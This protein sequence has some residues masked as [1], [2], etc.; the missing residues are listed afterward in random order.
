MGGLSRGCQPFV[1]RS[2]WIAPRV[3]RH[4]PKRYS[5]RSHQDRDVRSMNRRSSTCVLSGPIRLALSEVLSDLFWSVEITR[6]DLRLCLGDLLQLLGR[7]DEGASSRMRRGRHGRGSPNSR[8]ARRRGGK[9][10]RTG[11]RESRRRA[12][13]YSISRPR[14]K[15]SLVS[16]EPKRLLVIDGYSLQYRAL[17]ATRYLSTATGERLRSIR[18][19]P[20]LRQPLGPPSESRHK[21][22]LRLRN[23]TNGF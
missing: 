8:P 16:V 12:W 11:G 5:S 20:C 18:H 22:I 17:F 19:V 9:P 6:V 21:G 15:G 1:R 14:P 7:K 2:G 23:M 3:Q 4:N 13:L 10:R